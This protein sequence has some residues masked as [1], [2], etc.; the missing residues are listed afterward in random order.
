MVKNENLQDTVT[1]VKIISPL[2]TFLILK[3]IHIL[4]GLLR[5]IIVVSQTVGIKLGTK[6]SL[7]YQILNAHS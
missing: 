5:I 4:H 3:R 7:G 6:P 2:L 1:W